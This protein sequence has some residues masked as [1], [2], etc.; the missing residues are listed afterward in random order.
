MTLLRAW[1]LCLIPHGCTAVKSKV[2]GLLMQGLYLANRSRSL[3]QVCPGTGPSVTLK[4]PYSLLSLVHASTS[5]GIYS[6][7]IHGRSIS[8]EQAHGPLERLKRYGG[9]EPVE[10]GVSPDSPTRLRRDSRDTQ[11]MVPSP[12]HEPACLKPCPLQTS[13]E[14]K[15]AW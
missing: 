4:R 1:S 3:S 5:A 9:G 6:R 7:P 2:A 10:L 12:L 15:G 14:R 13:M 8:E 11:A